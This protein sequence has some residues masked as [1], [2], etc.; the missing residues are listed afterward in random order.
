MVGTPEEFDAVQPLSAQFMRMNRVKVPIELPAFCSW[1]VVGAVAGTTGL[2]LWA[3]ENEAVS[4]AKMNKTRFIASSVRIAGAEPFYLR[5]CRFQRKIS[6]ASRWMKCIG[7]LRKL[8][9]RGLER[10]QLDVHFHG[11]GLQLGTHSKP[12][13]WFPT[14]AVCLI[15][16]RKYQ[17]IRFSPS[18]TQMTTE[19]QHRGKNIPRTEP[20]PAAC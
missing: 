6:A 12:Y 10:G 9:H 4:S 16:P 20:F 7:L 2:G 8:R 3:A 14:A 15:A 17:N 19:R 13:A 11:S 5:P 1:I 18:E